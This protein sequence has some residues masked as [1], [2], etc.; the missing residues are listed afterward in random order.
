MNIRQKCLPN[1][2]L[3]ALK[4]LRLHAPSQ[5]RKRSKVHSVDPSTTEV[6]QSL[7][8]CAL[9]SEMDLIQHAIAKDPDALERLFK[10]YAPRLYRT[11]FAILR[12]KEDAED[13]LQD[14]WLRAYN[15]LS[16][17]EGRSSF[18]TWLTRI[19]INSALMIFRKNG[20]ALAVS[21]E[22][23]LGDPD[24][25]SCLSYTLPDP[26]Q[27]Y[28]QHQGR[29]L[30]CQAISALRPELRHV[31]QLK[32]LSDLSLRETARELGISIEAVKARA[33][34]AR[35][36]LRKSRAL[37][38]IARR[39]GNSLSESTSETHVAQEVE[40]KSEST[41]T[42]QNVFSGPTKSSELFHFCQALKLRGRK[43]RTR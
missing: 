8:P 11:A 30:L 43:D 31:V 14:S 1:P 32:Q 42:S 27:S 29:A 12:N 19:A 25:E 34:R 39:K 28:A 2:E 10:T 20:K 22:E 5:V 3:S 23:E 38:S 41:A 37:R 36:E 7:A 6:G 9:L 26:E 13:A 15:N 40:R 4:E 35:I 18:I 33:C 21:V 17:F 24:L 16:S